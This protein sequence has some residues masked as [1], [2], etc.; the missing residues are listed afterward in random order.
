MTCELWRCRR[1]GHR[2]AT[3][4][5]MGQCADGFIQ[6]NAPMVEDFLELGSC[7]AASMRSKMGFP[8]HIDGIQ[9]ARGT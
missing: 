8:A 7:F 3:E 5:E 4:L 9:P 2:R 1:R 6:H